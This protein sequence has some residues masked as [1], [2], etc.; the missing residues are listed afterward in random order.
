MGLAD[1]LQ[2]YLIDSGIKPV[3][4]IMKLFINTSFFL[5]QSTLIVKRKYKLLKHS[6]LFSIS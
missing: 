2:L 1:T 5:L 3:Y 6:N 4:I